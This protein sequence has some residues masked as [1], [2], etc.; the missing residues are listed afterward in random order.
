MDQWLHKIRSWI[1]TA[2]AGF[3]AAVTLI[4]LAAVIARYVFNRNLPDAYDAAVLAQ[5]IA[6]LWGIALT[7]FDGRHITVDIVFEQLRAK[8]RRRMDLVA[9]FISLVFLSLVAWMSLARALESQVSGLS[10]SQLRVPVWPF[11]TLA[12]LGLA[13]SVLTA[14]IRIY[15]L[16]KASEE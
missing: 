8:A 14:A 13:A 5:A 4:T 9:T 11:W 3:L 10:T 6:I 12:A 7:T 15:F 2:A 16:L 1:E